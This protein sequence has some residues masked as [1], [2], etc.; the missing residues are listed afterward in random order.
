MVGATGAGK[1]TL[2][3]IAAGTIP[4]TAGR[5]HLGD[6]PLRS[7]PSVELRRRVSMVSQEVHVFT[8]TVADNVRVAAP[9]SGGQDVRSALDTVG[10]ARWVRS[11]PEREH[12]VVGDGGY[13]LTP[14][15]EQMLALAR[16]VLADPEFIILDEATAEAGSSGARELESAAAAALAGRGALVVAHRL[17]QAVAADRVLVM[18]NGRVVES[19]THAQLSRGQGLYARLWEAWTAR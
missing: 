16:I 15:Q 2:A 10:A 1:S 14:M 11:L 9:G 8:G 19:G 5:V 4:A 7:L 18:E 13:R 6:R 12:T 17:S 3:Q